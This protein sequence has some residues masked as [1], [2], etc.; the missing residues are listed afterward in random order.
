MCFRSESSNRLSSTNEE[1]IDD[2]CEEISQ[3]IN[4]T[5]EPETSTGYCQVQQI[6]TNVFYQEL[7]LKYALQ[8][9]HCRVEE[10][11]G[12]VILAMIPNECTTLT[13]APFAINHG[14]A[15]K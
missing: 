10:Y 5:S 1:R 14:E 8:K 3:R 15:I 6:L 7:K 2:T 13:N 11:R 4:V 9:T 12:P